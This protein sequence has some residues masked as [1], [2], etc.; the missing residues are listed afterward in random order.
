MKKATHQT[1]RADVTDFMQIINI[2]PKMAKQFRE[3]GLKKPMDL[4]G[5]DPL[6][7]YQKS[8]KKRGEF[9]DPCALDC[10]ISAVDYMNGNSPKT[11]WSYTEK[12]KGKYTSD[13]DKLR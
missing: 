13:V 9:L 5:E 2:G 8:I 10:Y 12:R 4:K 11:W 7:L 1:E 3:I 6:R